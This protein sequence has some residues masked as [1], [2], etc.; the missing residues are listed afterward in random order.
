M[1]VDL[2]RLPRPILDHTSSCF[3]HSRTRTSSFARALSLFLRS[4]PSS[5]HFCTCFLLELFFLCVMFIFVSD[6]RCQADLI[7]CA[8]LSLFAHSSLALKGL[9]YVGRACAEC[10]CILCTF[11]RAHLLPE[12]LRTIPF[13]AV[14]R[15]LFLLCVCCFYAFHRSLLRRY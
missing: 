14:S 4:S 12:Y 2:L 11:T 9:R 10:Y 5:L 1:R 15:L 3:A 7:G 8:S 13:G 6:K